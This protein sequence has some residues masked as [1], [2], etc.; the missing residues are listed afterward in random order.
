MSIHTIN[1]TGYQGL[2]VF[3][4]FSYI[5]AMAWMATC[6]YWYLREQFNNIDEPP[7]KNFL[8]WFA[9]AILIDNAGAIPILSVLGWSAYVRTA[10]ALQLLEVVSFLYVLWYAIILT[11]LLWTRILPRLVS[12]YQ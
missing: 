11:G 4:S 3:D 10:E 5:P 2:H 7:F 9:L 1:L 12:R 8:S 6:A